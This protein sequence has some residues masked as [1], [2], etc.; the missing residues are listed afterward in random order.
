MSP[1][2][3]RPRTYTVHGAQSWR[4]ANDVVEGWLTRDGGQLGPV[5]F[6]TE[7]GDV[8]PFAVAPWSRGE[9]A[10]DA[11]RVLRNLRGDF[12]CL[13]FGVGGSPWNGENHPLH[14]ETSGGRWRLV[15]LA[16]SGDTTE[17]E[18]R[19]AVKSRPGVVTKRVRLKCGHTVLYCSHDIE[20]MSGPMCLGHHAM[21]RFPD[22]QGSGRIAFSPIRFGR[23][24]PAESAESGDLISSLRQGASFR[25][26]RRVPRKKGGYADLT[27]YPA[28]K[29][30][31][32]LVQ[33]AS[34][35]SRPVA[36]VAVSFPK[37]RYLWFALKNPK[38]LSST[39]LWYS[40]GGL[41]S[42]PW[43]GRNRP[44]L[45][46]EDV[47][48]FFDFGLAAS[49]KEN[50]FSRLGVPTTLALKANG[51]LRVHYVMGVTAVPRDFGAVRQV[52]FGVDALTFVSDS[53]ATV[54]QPVDLSFFYE[55]EGADNETF[56]NQ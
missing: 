16:Q 51:G 17:L 27:R 40:N 49:I 52:R 22:R 47:T 18:V 14:G 20:G 42:S 1:S 45:G 25:S 44:V 50:T 13:P 30:S 48:A 37:E 41:R 32:D 19:M 29:G 39:L 33:L 6:K 46:I 3:K 35:S 28:R 24:K 55:Q 43:D 15:S 31:D 26:L 34:R 12:F 53:G 5:S 2:M 23:V 11:P 38:Q 7:H 21:L 10:R 4:I 36:W 9:V 8:Q 56:R 54:R